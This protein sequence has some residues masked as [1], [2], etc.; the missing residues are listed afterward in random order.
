MIAEVF[1]GL[2][3]MN[4]LATLRMMVVLVA[5]GAL[6]RGVVDVLM[7]LFA[8]ARLDGGGGAAGL[9]GAALGVGA[10]LGSIGSAGLIG[11]S[12]LIPYL[13]ASSAVLAT[14]PYFGLARMEMLVPALMMF[15]LFG[16]SESML[17]VTTSSAFSAA[18]RM[19]CWPRIFGVAEALQM[20]LMALGSLLV[21]VLV[22]AIGLNG[23][24]AIIAHDDG[25]ADVVRHRSL[26]TT[27]RRRAAAAG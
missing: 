21:S 2:R 12:R 23:A 10:V 24:L 27:G 25:A 22:D 18:L 7:V 6:T 26:P 14:V 11:R 20:A 8:D 19:A 15:A 4:E 3:A 17:R 13:L 9:L 1:G 16:V 5:A